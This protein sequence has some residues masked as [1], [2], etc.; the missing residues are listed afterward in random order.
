MTMPP[1][2]QAFGIPCVT[3]LDT[4]IAARSMTASTLLMPGSSYISTFFQEGL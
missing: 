4:S 2:T 3:A 1:I